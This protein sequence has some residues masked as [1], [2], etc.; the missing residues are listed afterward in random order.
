MRP[1][2]GDPS[3]RR[4]E[5]NSGPRPPYPSLDSSARQI[6]PRLQASLELA[7]AAAA[8]DSTPSRQLDPRLQASLELAAAASEA[9]QEDTFVTNSL[10]EEADGGVAGPTMALQ[11][12]GP[13]VAASVTA[14]PG[15]RSPVP[16]VLPT[17]PAPT[18]PGQ[19]SRST[20][21]RRDDSM[22]RNR[23]Q[24][25]SAN[26][27][28]SSGS[29][30]SPAA[31]RMP[32][33]VGVSRSIQVYPADLQT[34]SGSRS[35]SW[36][37]LATVSADPAPSG[38]SADHMKEIQALFASLAKV[39]KRAQVREE[40]LLSEIS[41][42]Q[43]R[44]EDALSSAEAADRR[45][46]EATAVD[47]G[48]RESSLA[49]IPEG[50]EAGAAA[51]PAQFHPSPRGVPWGAPSD[52]MRSP[53]SPRLMEGRLSPR[54]QM[55]TAA[56]MSPQPSWNVSEPGTSSREQ[57]REVD[58]VGTVSSMSNYEDENV[59]LRDLVTRL[60]K[61]K[62]L[63]YERLATLEMQHMNMQGTGI[64]IGTWSSR[65]A[66]GRPDEPPHQVLDLA[67]HS[68]VPSISGM[69][70]DSY[71]APGGMNDPYRR[72][73]ARADSM[74]VMSL[75]DAQFDRISLT[76]SQSMLPPSP[77]RDM[78]S[79]QRQRPRV[80]RLPFMP[81]HGSAGQQEVGHSLDS[82]RSV[83]SRATTPPR[84]QQTPLD[85][86]SWRSD[87]RYQSSWSRDLATS[88]KQLS[89][90]GAAS[91]SVSLRQFEQFQGISTSD[92]DNGRSRGSRASLRLGANEMGSAAQST[93]NQTPRGPDSS[94]TS[95]A[96]ARNFAQK[97]KARDQGT[98]NLLSWG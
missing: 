49:D 93:P 54:T 92:R 50:T 5:G 91:P 77:E 51:P 68:R 25:A 17:R 94:G 14:A 37:R 1:R 41:K 80:P 55:A 2:P 10:G 98:L 90:R 75:E 88:P 60:A 31:K 78:A 48:R 16:L 34:S 57:A 87:H 32:K 67:R 27:G 24:P 84:G 97:M 23:Q 96:E 4:Y 74:S 8:A 65:S 6:D 38:A 83:D 26:R 28:A 3:D 11:N 15:D 53:R 43:E 18:Q 85:Q 59:R 81:P 86:S 44:L 30:V 63:Y 79:A 56:A 9:P 40:Q 12:S 29:G 72:R 89:P 58:E 45:A 35:S 70:T 73:E 13:R 42:L 19:A 36:P 95:A 82:P 62:E 22:R 71:Q 76:G 66:T 7:A 39:K 61:D 47:A 33:K 20:D 46:R 69:S 21:L 52:G 64:P